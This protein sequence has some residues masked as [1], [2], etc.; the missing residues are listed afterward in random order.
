MFGSSTAAAFGA[1]LAPATLVAQLTI[2]SA[3][4]PERVDPGSTLSFAA[5][6]PKPSSSSKSYELRCTTMAC[7]SY[8]STKAKHV[9][10]VAGLQQLS[11]TSFTV[12]SS[13]DAGTPLCFEVYLPGVHLNNPYGDG[14]ISPVP[15]HVAASACATVSTPFINAAASGKASAGVSAAGQASPPLRGAPR[16]A[17]GSYS[18]SRAPSVARSELGKSP[19]LVI[20]FVNTPV[21]RWT[22]RNIGTAASPATRVEF[23]RLGVAETQSKYVGNLAPGQSLEITVTPELDMYLVNSTAT[24]DPDEKVGEADETNNR[25]ASKDSR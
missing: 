8:S 3:P 21:A 19:D 12:P 14:V 10:E 4:D 7:K 15:D 9:A 5:I 16:T 17:S 24:V 20:T 25:W 2:K 23:T 1:I 11:F 18:E 13:A 6:V 22:V